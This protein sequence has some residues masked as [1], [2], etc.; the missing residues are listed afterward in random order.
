M[1]CFPV[2]EDALDVRGRG[3]ENGLGGEPDVCRPLPEAKEDPDVVVFGSERRYHP[4]AYVNAMSWGSD[5]EFATFGSLGI[6]TQPTTQRSSSGISA[7]CDLFDD[8]DNDMCDDWTGILYCA[9]DHSDS[10]Y[11]GRGRYGASGENVDCRFLETLASAAANSTMVNDLTKIRS[12]P[13][14]THALFLCRS[15]RTTRARLVERLPQIFQ[16]YQFHVETPG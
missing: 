13:G 1:S 15:K 12:Q 5:V 11:L 6:S 16:P 3:I 14:R 8:E 4:P 9:Y 2:T 7:V 10:K